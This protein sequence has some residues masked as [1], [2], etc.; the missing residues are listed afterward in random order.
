MKKII[1]TDLDGTLLNNTKPE[2]YITKKNQKAILKWLKAGNYF[3]LATGRNPES[4]KRIYQKYPKLFNLPLVLSNGSVIFDFKNQTI[5][6]EDIINSD[7]IKEVIEYL[8]KNENAIPA[9]STKTKSYTIKLNNNLK[10]PN[11]LTV[12]SEERLK[13]LK[14]NK[15]AF[16][17]VNNNFD[18]VFNDLN[19]FKNIDKIS[20][21]PSSRVYLEVVN[22]ETDKIN[23]IKKAIKLSNIDNYQLFTIG[24]YINDLKMIQQSDYSF[25]PKN[26]HQ[27]LL[28]EAN[29]IVNHHNKDALSHMIDI[30]LNNKY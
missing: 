22:K 13:T 25:A 12:V 2:S 14:I 6:Y 26:D 5:L 3:S 9:F 11:Y 24:D 21:V 27:Q 30:I 8:K 17:I 1:Y 29:F 7:F 23:G 10:I 28:D 16:I 4:I 18:E 19:N 20:I 15:F